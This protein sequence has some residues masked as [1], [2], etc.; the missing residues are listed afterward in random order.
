MS[1]AVT[2]ERYPLP[3]EE[4]RWRSTGMRDVDGFLQSSGID[5]NFL[6]K[7][8]LARD[9]KSF[10]DFNLILDF[11][12]GCGRLI[13]SLRPL[14]DPWATIQGVD[15]DLA[16]IKWCKENISDAIFSVNG[17]H[18]PLPFADK[19]FDLISACAVF[20]HMD[21]DRQF[22]WLAELQRVLK[23]GGY[24]LATFRHKQVY[25]IEDQTIRERILNDLNRDGIAFMTTDAWKGVFPAWYGETYHTPE[26]IRKN[27]GSYFEV[28]HVVTTTGAIAEE[29]AVLRPRDSTFLQRV[30][31]RP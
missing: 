23:P 5:A 19:S 8:V 12:C 4:L 20:T 6:D 30:F 29:T 31:K 18:P 22:R 24:L 14:C 26:Y 27:W 2:T 15:I 21:A 9:S 11:G 1:Q 3:P 16:A 7:E 13:R 25:Q 10:K 17:E 28:R